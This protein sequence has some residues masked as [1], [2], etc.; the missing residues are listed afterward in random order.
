M[1]FDCCVAMSARFGMDLDLTKLPAQDRA[2]CA[3]AVSAY[4]KIR[5][6]TALGDLY[7]LEDPHGSY[8]GAI[9][10]VSPDQSRAIMFAFQLD[11]GPNAAVR[12]QGLAPSKRY[13][14]HELN[15]MPGR[16]AIAQEGQ[17]QTGEELM[18]DGV[19]PSCSKA[20]EA[21]IIELHE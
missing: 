14:I 6:V 12:L 18:R 5:G 15:P 13:T 8:R 7:R 16:A 10:F 4:K 19:L 1:H 9:D 2:I 11:D 17:M 21:S 20:L 3:G